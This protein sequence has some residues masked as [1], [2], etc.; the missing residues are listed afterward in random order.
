MRWNLNDGSNGVATAVII[1][2]KDASKINAS[3]VAA[4]QKSRGAK[5][6]EGLNTRVLACSSCSKFFYVSQKGYTNSAN[7]KHKCGICSF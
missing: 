2:F 7:H 4:N 6:L 5:S 3:L 1:R